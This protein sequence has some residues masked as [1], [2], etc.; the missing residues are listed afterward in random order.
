[1]AIHSTAIIDPR[2]TIDPSVEIGAYVVVD[3]VVQ[4]GAGTRIFPHAYITGWTEIGANC[5]IHPGAVVGHVPQDLAFEKKESYCRIGE[6]TV[7]RE[8]A[9]IHRGTDAGSATVIGKRCHLMANAHVGHNCRVGDDVKMTNGAVLG[10]HVEI[11]EGA[12]LSG[13][14]GVH[15]F[16]RIGELVMAGGVQRIVN[17]VPPYFLVV[18]NGCCA[19]VNLVG[20]KRAGFSKEQRAEVREAYRILYRSG[21]TFQKAI[22]V[23]ADAVT[24]DPGKRIVA[25]LR[26]PSKR[27]IVSAR[28]RDN[29]EHEGQG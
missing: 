16:V 13:Y 8:G 25:F 11:G 1:M 7:I 4:I 2:A 3:G 20:M 18:D 19:G 28:R 26:E 10:G 23:L 14:V 27:G 29:R 6:G 5:E 24:T 9:S 12:F 22:D 15:Q 21:M 17:D